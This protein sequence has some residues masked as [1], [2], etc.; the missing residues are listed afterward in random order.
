MTAVETC[1]AGAQDA[2][3]PQSS[4]ARSDT[5]RLISRL[6]LAIYQ[7]HLPELFLEVACA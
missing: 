5:Y 2:L 7:I 3:G 4:D 6:T 1:D